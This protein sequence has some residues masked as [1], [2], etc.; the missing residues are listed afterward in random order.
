MVRVSLES[1]EKIWMGSGNWY[2]IQ[3]F[4]ESGLERVIGACIAN[5]CD[6]TEQ[7]GSRVMEE[8]P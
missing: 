6:L 2:K 3:C 4:E 1:C 5:A 7:P 8:M